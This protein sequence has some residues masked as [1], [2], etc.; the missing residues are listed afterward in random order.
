MHTLKVQNSALQNRHTTKLDAAKALAAADSNSFEDVQ[1]RR[2]WDARRPS[3]VKE[4]KDLVEAGLLYE[5]TMNAATESLNA[6]FRTQIGFDG[7]RD[8][9]R[10][11]LEERRLLQHENLL[12]K[13][14]GLALAPEDLKL[15]RREVRSLRPQKLM[16]VMADSRLDLWL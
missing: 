8:S 16:R 7:R 9:L 1:T 12:V 5:D 15:F 4:I 11:W 13:V 14:G 3:Q 2:I 10:A 6:H